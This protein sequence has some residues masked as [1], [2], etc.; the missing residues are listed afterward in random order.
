MA[1]T[2]NQLKDAP[3]LISKL[4]AKMFADKI[5]FCKSID[6]EPAESYNGVN[7]YKSGDTIQISKPARFGVGTTADIT[8]AIQDVDEERSPRPW[9][10]FLRDSPGAWTVQGT[11]RG[12]SSLIPFLVTRRRYERFSSNGEE[13]DQSGEDTRNSFRSCK[14]LRRRNSSPRARIGPRLPRGISSSRASSS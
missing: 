8:S 3:G 1:N 14:S 6:I 11:I 7:G 13:G 2:I 5:V 10:A 12:R 4:A 9:K